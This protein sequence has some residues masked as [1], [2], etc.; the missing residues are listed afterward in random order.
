MSHSCRNHHSRLSGTGTLAAVFADQ[1]AL[2]APTCTAPSPSPNDP[3]LVLDTTLMATGTVTTSVGTSTAF[4]IARGGN[5]AAYGLVLFSTTAPVRVNAFFVPTGAAVAQFVGVSTTVTTT[6][7]TS[8][9]QLQRIALTFQTVCPGTLFFTE[10]TPAGSV[11]STIAVLA[12]SEIT[13]TEF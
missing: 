9:P 13:V 8:V 12:G 3:R 7:P 10:C 5:V 1:P 4:T 11:P 6:S 2:T